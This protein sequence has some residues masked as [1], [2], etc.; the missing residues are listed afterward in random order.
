VSK[1]ELRNFSIVELKLA[2]KRII[3]CYVNDLDRKPTLKEIDS[4]YRSALIEFLEEKT[5]WFHKEKDDPEN[6]RRARA[7]SQKER[8]EVENLQLSLNLRAS[9]K[10]SD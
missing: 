7:V 9:A 10:D 1:K 8:Q 4:A 2:I 5:E 3:R 6:L